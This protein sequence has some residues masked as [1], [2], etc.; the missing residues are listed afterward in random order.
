MAAT[1]PLPGPVGVSGRL[2]GLRCARAVPATADVDTFG[3]AAL[4][5]QVGADWRRGGAPVAAEIAERVDDLVGDLV[6]E[7][8]RVRDEILSAVARKLGIGRPLSRAVCDEF[9]LRNE[10]QMPGGIGL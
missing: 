7:E 5:V 6:L 9:A 4:R 2:D 8:L 10:P 3:V 1:R